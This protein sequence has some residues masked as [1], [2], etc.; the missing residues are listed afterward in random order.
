MNSPALLDLRSIFGVEARVTTPASTTGGAY[1]E[2]ECIAEPGSGTMVHYHP[3]QEESFHVLEGGLELLSDRKWIP[4]PAG[5]SHTVPKGAIHAWRNAS[6]RPTRFVNVHRPAGG[7]QDQ[8]E[9]LDRLV[10]AGKVR[11]TKDLRSI[12]HMS[13]AAVRHRPDVTVK[14]PQWMVNF[15]AFL[16][17]RLGYS[18]DE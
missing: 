7:F 3:Q 18:L 9:T 2:M 16:G 10:K 12:I 17:R 13:M 5:A 8:M 4:V 6:D 1:V 14:P 15:M 11:G